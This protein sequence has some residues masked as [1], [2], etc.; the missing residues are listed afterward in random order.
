VAVLKERFDV[1]VKNI[2]QGKDP[3]KVRIVIE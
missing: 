3:V 1:F 2:T